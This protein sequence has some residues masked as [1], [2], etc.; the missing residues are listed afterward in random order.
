MKTSE[1][2]SN[3]EE[4]IRIAAD[5]TRS[6][7]RLGMLN[8]DPY[9][10][11][12][13]ERPGKNDI[14]DCYVHGIIQDAKWYRGLRYS[15]QEDLDTALSALSADNSVSRVSLEAL[16]EVPNRKPIKY[17]EAVS[18]NLLGNSHT[19]KHKD[20]F[21]AMSERVKSGKS[22]LDLKTLYDKLVSEKNE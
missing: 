17:M 5:G 16:G 4:L 14:S 20:K 7:Y 1:M 13:V 10:G 6:Y 8:R 12:A 22:L 2:S 11:P 9:V 18:T 3:I 19:P 21:G 15:N